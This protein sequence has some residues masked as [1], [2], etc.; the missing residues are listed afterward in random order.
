MSEPVVP[1]PV[2]LVAMF[3]GTVPA[4]ITRSR[5]TGGVDVHFDRGNPVEF[6]PDDLA[7][8]KSMAAKVKAARRFRP[9][10]LSDA[11]RDA[12]PGVLVALADRRASL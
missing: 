12:L 10:R 7:S 8:F 5:D 4:V 2:G 9:P 1:S 3:C 11:E 6:L